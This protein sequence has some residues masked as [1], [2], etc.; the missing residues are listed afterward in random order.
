MPTGASTGVDRW[1]NVAGY[2]L[3]YVEVGHGQPAQILGAGGPCDLAC[4]D[5]A[6]EHHGPQIGGREVVS[7]HEEGR[8]TGDPG[9]VILERQECHT[10]GLVLDWGFTQNLEGFCR[11]SQSEEARRC[12]T[13]MERTPIFPS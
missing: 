9:A 3:H 8:E 6:P 5:G 1:V 4:Q 7:S 13:S 2:Y 11:R 10:C 12:C